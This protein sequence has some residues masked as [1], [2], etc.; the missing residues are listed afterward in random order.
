VFLCCTLGRRVVH[1]YCITTLQADSILPFWY[2]RINSKSRLWETT[3]AW[4]GVMPCSLHACPRV[5][6]PP[7]EVVFLV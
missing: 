4:L 3:S 1:C 7:G 2:Q 6:C 5:P